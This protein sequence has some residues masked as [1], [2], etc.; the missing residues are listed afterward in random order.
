S[1]LSH[2][3]PSSPVE[4]EV[5]HRVWGGS[6]QRYRPGTL[7]FEGRASRAWARRAAPGWG[8][9]PAV[10]TH[11]ASEAAAPP[12]SFARPAA[13]L[14][15]PP[16]KGGGCVGHP[17]DADVHKPFSLSSVKLDMTYRDCAAPE[18]LALGFLLAHPEQTDPGGA[19][20]P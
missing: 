6:R 8:G 7:P 19:H 4:G 18:A 15:Y 3:L 9:L 11:H 16:L 14:R 17:I 1:G 12:P 5:L 2:P 13:K 20:A 10:A